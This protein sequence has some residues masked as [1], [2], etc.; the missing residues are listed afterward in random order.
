[1]PPPPLDS[2]SDP[3]IDALFAR[4]GANMENRRT[5]LGLSIRAAAKR[6]GM[7]DRTYSNLESPEDRPTVA[8]QG[9]TLAK[10]AQAAKGLGL[11]VWQ[12]LVPDFDGEYPPRLLAR[13]SEI[14]GLTPHELRLIAAL[15]MDPTGMRLAGILLSMGLPAPPISP[16]PPAEA[17]PAKKTAAKKRS[18]GLSVSNG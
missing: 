1:M 4:L 7:G 14:T 6:G 17:R 15:R 8:T 11:E 13:N 3:Y 10:I 5:H 12:L 2:D 9:P 16:P 18:G